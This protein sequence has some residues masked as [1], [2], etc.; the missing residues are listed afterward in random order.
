MHLN[1][2]NLV[3][4]S[5]TISAECKL[6]LSNN[7][8]NEK[9]ETSDLISFLVDKKL[10]IAI[11]WKGEFNPGEIAD[12]IISRL[13]KFDVDFTINDKELQQKLQAKTSKKN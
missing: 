11:D 6:I 8:L 5:L 7:G 1:E 3:I 12:F 9:S 10:L 13:K 4:K 2:I